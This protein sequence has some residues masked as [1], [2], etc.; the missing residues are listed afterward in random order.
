MAAETG[1]STL[2]AVGKLVVLEWGF[3]MGGIDSMAALFG[4]IGYRVSLRRHRLPAGTARRLERPRQP[5]AAGIADLGQ[6]ALC[7][8]HPSVACLPVRNGG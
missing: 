6:Q 3:A 1:S 4:W 8:A 7:A 2:L 5:A